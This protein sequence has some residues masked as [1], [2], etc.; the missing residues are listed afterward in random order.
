MMKR[1]LSS[2]SQ[3]NYKRRC[4]ILKDDAKTNYF[5]SSSD[6]D[7]LTPSNPSPSKQ[8]GKNDKNCTIQTVDENQMYS[9]KSI[10]DSS[11]DGENDEINGSKSLSFNDTQYRLGV[12]KGIFKDEFSDEKLLDAVN[13][14]NGLDHAV[15]VLIDLKDEQGNVFVILGAKTWDIWVHFQL[16]LR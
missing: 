11:S 5:E 4:P 1:K 7:S 13:D 8:L 12:L 10:L 16:G 9:S 6:E 14:T 2:L 3:F 15:S